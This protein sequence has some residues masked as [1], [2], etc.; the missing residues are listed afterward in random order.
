[1]RTVI[2]TGYTITTK[3]ST[4]DSPARKI[5]GS[6]AM[7]N[8]INIYHLKI[9]W[10]GSVFIHIEKD[11][12]GLQTL[13]LKILNQQLSGTTSLRGFPIDSLLLPPLLS[14]TLKLFDAT[15]K[16][17]LLPLELRTS[18]EPTLINL[19]AALRL[20]PE[21][22]QLELTIKQ[23]NYS[24][25]SEEGFMKTATLVNLY[26]AYN[27]ILNE[28]IA[29]RD[30]RAT[31]KTPDAVA[32]FLAWHH[33]SRV[34][35][36]IRQ[37]GFSAKLHLEKNDPLGFLK[38]HSIA[39]RMEKRAATL[40]HQAIKS[41]R[42]K[43]P[44]GQE[45][46]CRGYAQLSQKYLNR[47]R[48]LQPYLSGGFEE[49]AGIN[50]TTEEKMK[51]AEVTAYYDVWEQFN[52]A[53]TPQLIYQ[54]FIRLAQGAFDKNQY[55]AALQML[56]NASQ[57]ETWFA[58]IIP[59]ASRAG[60]YN[61][62]LDG[63][64]SSYLKVSRIAYKSGKFEMAD[65]YYHKAL[66]VFGHYGM[67]L[68]ANMTGDPV[69]L[70]FTKLQIEIAKDL[71]ADSQWLKTLVLLQRTGEIRNCHETDSLCRQ[72]DSLTSLAHKGV[73]A[74]KM[75]A[76]DELISRKDF[77]SATTALMLASEYRLRFQKYFSPNAN[78]QLEKRANP[79]FLAC[80]QKG[81]ELLNSSQPD[82]ALSYFLKA[83]E[84]EKEYLPGRDT[85][86]ETLLYNATVPVILGKIESARFE[87]WAYRMDKADSLYHV[88]RQ[89]QT[90]YR[91]QNNEELNAAF[92]ALKVKM[93]QRECVGINY[94]LIS[95]NELAVNAVRAGKFEKAEKL[96]Q[97][98]TRLLYSRENCHPDSTET[99]MLKKKYT[100]LFTYLN[101]FAEID[102]AVRESEFDTAIFR[103]ASLK[104][105]YLQENL[106]KFGVSKPSLD[107]Y[108][109]RKNNPELTKAAIRFFVHK[110]EYMR[111]LC[112]L[113][114]LKEQQPAARDAREVQQLLGNGIGQM[115]INEEM[116]KQVQ[117]C[118]GNDSWYIY[119]KLARLRAKV[120][121]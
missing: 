4:A 111:A 1:M 107:I 75:Q 49:M 30:S 34:N 121:K 93:G 100:G 23:A 91:Q 77:D 56:Q 44:S 6:L 90:N 20:T 50:P 114:L 21:P 52:K 35:A 70:H 16:S 2:H 33:I 8:G 102:L 55:V 3:M 92:E 83:R 46:Y 85:L 98:S 73:F 31:T 66:E 64:M 14:G 96:L 7:N 48:N 109:G 13:R 12:S 113:P 86:L 28:L 38:R 104:S 106:S 54:Q 74:K 36:Y 51:L 117:A 94:R 10:Q 61:Q 115:D 112:F 18:G 43:S 53:S 39:L 65:T 80:F 101:H 41:G 58:Q 9:R 120:L 27:K 103:F 97:E 47:A 72:I 40:F 32:T 45:K 116:E 63:L 99:L 71:L 62:S 84:V 29:A 78:T 110:D 68:G 67:P 88:A 95:L 11:S 105:L 19:P 69:F 22:E 25:L 89:M 79:I 119:F 87:T 76:I 118:T 37:H 17:I 26:F 108:L 42:E 59:S 5:L 15:G 57:I 82:K 24:L 81:E 60:L